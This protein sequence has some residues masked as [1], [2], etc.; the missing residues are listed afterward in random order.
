VDVQ[1]SPSANPAAQKP[2]AQPVN[3]HQHALAGLFHLGHGMGFQTQLF[4]DKGLYE[5]LGRVL[6]CS[7][8]G[9]YES[10]PIRGALPIPFNPQPE[11]FKGLQPPLHFSER[12]L[13]LHMGSDSGTSS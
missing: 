7:L 12:N 13:E 6:S 11:A 9:N 10:K 2:L 3:V 4:S 8:V 1:A 5:H